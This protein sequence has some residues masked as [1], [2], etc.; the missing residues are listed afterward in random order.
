MLVEKPQ[1]SL[2]MPP[3]VASALLPT[4]FSVDS[5]HIQTETLKWLLGA[6]RAFFKLPH[7]ARCTCIVGFE[8]Q[9]HW[10]REVCDSRHTSA[11][12]CSVLE[13]AIAASTRGRGERATLFT[14]TT[15]PL[16]R[17]LAFR[18]SEAQLVQHLQTLRLDFDHV[19]ESIA[20]NHSHSKTRALEELKRFET[21]QLPRHARN[22]VARALTR[23]NVL[24]GGMV[25]ACAFSLAVL[26]LLW[27]Q[28]RAELCERF[29]I[30][31][32]ARS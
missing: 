16:M 9:P 12:A 18:D 1:H 19:L 2:F 5:G 28:R 13:S 3:L 4:R 14:D 8:N 7:L 21:E 23:S 10:E 11:W 30:I 31:T 20:W 6:M 29:G 25:Y 17:S 22:T 32:R 15:F 27:A 26:R 24:F